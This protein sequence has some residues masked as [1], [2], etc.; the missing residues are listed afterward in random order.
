MIRICG[1]RKDTITIIVFFKDF[2]L[3][4][5]FYYLPSWHQVAVVPLPRKVYQQEVQA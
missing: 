4:R 2:G 1:W 5:L 3:P